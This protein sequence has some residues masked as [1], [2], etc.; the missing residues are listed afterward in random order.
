[1]PPTEA[2]RIVVLVKRFPRLSETFI[3][4]EFLEL[5][6]QGLPVD[7][8]AIMDP[9]EDRSQPEALALV[10]E[11][12]YLQAGR[13]W[14]E[15]PAVARTAR[16]YPL[17]T[18]QAAWWTLTRRT[19]AA[20]R[21]FLH[22]LILVDRLADGPPAHLHAHFLHSPAALAFLARKISGQPY[23]LTGH[24]KDIYTSLPENLRFRCGRARFVTTCTEANRT[25]L[26]SEVGVPL[27]LVHLCRHGIDLDRF[28]IPDRSP[29]PGRLVTVGRLV[30]KKGFDVLIRACGELKRRG[31]GFDL[32]IL[33]GGGL[34][35]EL[36]AL[37]R[38]QGIGDQVTLL[39]SRP[40]AEVIEQLAAAEVFALSPVVLPSGDRDGIPN[41]LLE[42]MAAG[43][44]VVATMVSGIPEV[45]TDGD[46]GRLVP[47]HRPDLLA[48][49]LA[50]LLTSDDERGRL[51]AAGREHALAHASWASVI[52]PLRALLADQLTDVGREHGELAASSQR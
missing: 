14:D 2:Q 6:R 42:A 48:D 20:A 49:A 47:P 24:A 22:A 3:L 27:Q 41:V 30:P 8:F 21:N 46:T 4:N 52:P 7:L 39:G 38:E 50:D 44:P 19:I 28:T 5:R 10:P 9:H 13:L 15:L 32:V 31:V 26:V 51:G 45:I 11:V 43:V 34:R 16:R 25:H 35:D 17:G 36:A 1:M 18:L 40:Q 33:G 37:A 12:T 23:S 29:R